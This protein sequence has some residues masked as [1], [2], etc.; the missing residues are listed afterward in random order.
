MTVLICDDDAST[1]FAV[2]RLLLRHLDCTV[3]E[4]GNGTEAIA[5]LD[6]EPVHLMLLDIE[7][8]EMSGVEVLSV[9]RA[10]ASVR[11]LPVVMMSRERREEVVRTLVRLGIDGYVLKPLRADRMLAALEPLRQRIDRQMNAV[12]AGAP[13]PGAGAD[14]GLPAMLVDGDS[15]AR[16]RFV[17]Q[18]GAVGALLEADSGSAALAQFKRQ[19][20][21]LVFVGTRLGLLTRERLVARLRTLAAPRRIRVVALVDGRLDGPAPDGCDHAIAGI[22]DATTLNA[23]LRRFA[24]VPGMLGRSSVRLGDIEECLLESAQQICTMMLDVPVVQTFG[25]I[26]TD[27]EG[28][29]TAT[30][31]I[32]GEVGMQLSTSLPASSALW[33]AGRMFGKA[34]DLTSDDDRAAAV[35][36]LGQLFALRLRDWLDAH[37]CACE[38]EAPVS[39]HGPCRWER[40]PARTPAVR[41]SFEVPGRGI[42]VLLAL[43][44]TA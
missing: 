1:R 8:P 38:C 19:P 17:A 2:K 9:V 32:T 15:E 29:V 43:D 4:C 35:A 5:R 25:A 12:T 37:G 23:G 20:S 42:T 18:A 40:Q 31:A 24:P 16:Q 36:E 3:I 34:G 10:S 26:V 6:G 41:V 30:V 27:A 44:F 28:A 14:T 21:G 13:A 7:M 11:Q 33:V 22:D 39:R